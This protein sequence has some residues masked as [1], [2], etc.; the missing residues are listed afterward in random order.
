MWRRPRSVS[1]CGECLRDPFPNHGRRK[2]SLHPS[3]SR[4]ELHIAEMSATKPGAH[5]VIT[6]TEQFE[7]PEILAFEDR[8]LDEDLVVLEAYA[9]MAVSADLHVEIS[10]RADRLSVAYRCIPGELILHA[11]AI[12]GVGHC[13]GRRIL[14]TRPTNVCQPARLA[15]LRSSADTRWRVTPRTLAMRSVVAPSMRISR[16]WARRSR[17]VAE[18][19]PRKESGDVDHDS[20]LAGA[21]KLTHRL[22]LPT[23]VANGGGVFGHD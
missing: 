23:M 11:L 3:P 12:Q 2:Q 21:R 10:T 18:L 19:S 15:S 4:A 22:A 16:A 8:V 14:P 5:V 1:V 17:V 20:A 13:D 7:L 6:F 9:D